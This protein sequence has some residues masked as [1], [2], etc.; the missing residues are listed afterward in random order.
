MK[1][2][3]SPL[4]I[5]QVGSMVEHIGRDDPAAAESICSRIH[6]RVEQLESFPELGPPGRLEGTRQLM[7]T[8]TKY[9]VVYEVTSDA[10]VVLDVWHVAQSRRRRRLH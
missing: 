5:E 10:V 1:V 7:V 6:E 9:V 8:G 2:V 3:W 4:A